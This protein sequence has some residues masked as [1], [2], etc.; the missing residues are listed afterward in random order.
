[1]ERSHMNEQI[2]LLA[3]QAGLKVESFMTNPPKPFQILGSTEQFEKFAELIV[4]ECAG[5]DFRRKVGLTDYLGYE[6]G[7][8]IKSHFGVKE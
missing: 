4:K 8:V 6:I 2:K 3:E 1:M 5:I 7:K